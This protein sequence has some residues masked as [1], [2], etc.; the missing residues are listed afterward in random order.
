MLLLL[1]EHLGTDEIA[2][3]LFISEH[4]VRSHV[5]S[6]LR[7]LGA[8]SRGEALQALSAARASEV[9]SDD[10]RVSRRLLTPSEAVARRGRRHEARQRRDVVAAFEHGRDARAIAAH[11]RA[12]SRNPSSLTPMSASGILDVR[13]EAGRDEQ[14]LGLEAPSSA[15]RSAP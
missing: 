11:R 9:R 10:P 6:L 4:T 14:E 12:S 5:K 7:K 13:V 3:R 2:K 15:A 8:S 1:D